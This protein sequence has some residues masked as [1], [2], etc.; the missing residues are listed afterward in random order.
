MQK[1]KTI[2]KG[3]EIPKCKTRFEEPT[4]FAEAGKEDSTSKF[5]RESLSTTTETPRKWLEQR[6]DTWREEEVAEKMGEKES[7]EGLW[8]LSEKN[9]DFF[10]LVLVFKM[11][12]MH[13]EEGK[14]P[15]LAFL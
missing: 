14:G 15:T 11:K 12:K 1:Q 4:F 10:F 2:Q 7:M 5:V 8:S 13:N 3:K 9:R 6:R